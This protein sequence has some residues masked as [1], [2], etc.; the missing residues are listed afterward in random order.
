[1]PPDPSELPPLTAA[2]RFL[3]FRGK[4]GLLRP[5]GLLWLMS[6]SHQELSGK[7]PEFV[8]RTCKR[9]ASKTRE[10]LTP[11]N[12]WKQNSASA[13]PVYLITEMA[14]HFEQVP[15]KKKNKICKQE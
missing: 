10:S 13:F 5:L 9:E 8:C 7:Q 1:V 4:A 3:T 12:T 2:G 11:Q 15:S 14:M 6:S